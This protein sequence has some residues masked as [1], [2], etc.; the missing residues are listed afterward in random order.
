MR[1]SGKDLFTAPI[2]LSAAFF[3]FALAIIEKGLKWLHEHFT[4]PPATAIKTA[5]P[6]RTKYVVERALSEEVRGK[7]PGN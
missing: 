2:F 3:V 1:E 7:T 6:M 5:T 4:V